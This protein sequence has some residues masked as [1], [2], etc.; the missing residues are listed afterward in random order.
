LKNNPSTD[1]YLSKLNIL[2]EYI[3]LVIEKKDHNRRVFAIYE[4]TGFLF[5]PV[6]RITDCGHLTFEEYFKEQSKK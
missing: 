6:Y 2:K 1:Y 4:E 5:R 3:G